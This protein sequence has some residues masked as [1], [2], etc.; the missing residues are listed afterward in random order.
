MYLRK[1]LGNLECVQREA[2][3]TRVSAITYEEQL[4]KLGMFDLETKHATYII[5][6]YVKFSLFSDVPES[7]SKRQG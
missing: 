4:K 5:S 1:D 3:K 6:L 7:R 2:K